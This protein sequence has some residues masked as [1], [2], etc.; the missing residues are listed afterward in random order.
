MAASLLERAIAQAVQEEIQYHDGPRV[1]AR[2]ITDYMA[3]RAL[4]E[5]SFWGAWDAT[6]REVREAFAAAEGIN[7][8]ED[9]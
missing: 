2:R 4:I 7:Q 5:D 6:V 8:C 9:V 3:H 1:A